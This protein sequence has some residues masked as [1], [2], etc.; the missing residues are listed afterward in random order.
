ME[1][2]ECKE[3]QPNVDGLVSVAIFL[4]GIKLGRGGNIHPLGNIEIDN[5]WKAIRFLRYAQR[6]S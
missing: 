1:K 4:E 3:E 5:L 2:L 6:E